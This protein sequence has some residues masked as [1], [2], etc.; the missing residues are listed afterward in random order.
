MVEE[1]NW[2]FLGKII[3]K[4]DVNTKTAIMKA[5][6]FVTASYFH[7]SKIFLGKTGAQKGAPLG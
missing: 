2:R 4:F 5:C 7:L 1:V 3:T 6:L